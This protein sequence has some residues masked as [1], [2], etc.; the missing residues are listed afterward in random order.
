[1]VYLTRKEHFNAA[2]RL[3]NPDW[4]DDKN[5][6]MFGICANPNFHGHNFELWVTVSGDPN[7]DTGLVMDAKKLGGI[8]KE[9]ILDELDHKNMNMDV[10]WLQ[11]IMPSTENVVIQIWKRLEPFITGARLHCVK[12]QET[13]KIYA[14]YYGNE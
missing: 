10:P 7:P 4:S 14:E 5:S 6:D 12:L 3:Y 9:V 8:M 1:M 2:H 13:P 11:G